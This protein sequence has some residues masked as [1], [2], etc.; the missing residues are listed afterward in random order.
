MAYYNKEE[1]GYILFQKF[2]NE[3]NP[4]RL[5]AVSGKEGYLISWAVDN[6]AKKY[7]GAEFATLDISEIDCLEEEVESIVGISQTVSMFSK[8]RLIIVRN[9]LESKEG[10]KGKSEIERILGS[11]E[12]EAI[13][14]FVFE[15]DAKSGDEKAIYNKEIYKYI[16]EHGRTFKFNTLDRDILKGFIVKRFKDSNREI[17][18]QTVEFLIN[19]SNYLNKDSDYTLYN[20]INDISKIV[21]VGHG[22]VE[23]EEILEVISSSMESN[24]FALLDAI[25]LGNKEEAFRLARDII[26]SGENVFRLIASVASQVELLLMVKEMKEEKASIGEM[27]NVLKKSK[28]PVQKAYGFV[29][30]LSKERL[31]KMLVH[32]YS[33]D[34]NIKSGK[35]EGN[36]A[37]E[38]FIAMA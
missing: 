18:S 37:L 21:D 5:I 36:F 20:L 27:V 6:L 3:E 19:E 8:Q 29:D 13:I 16:E 33:C 31:K 22:A 14:V 10:L 24:S 2:L 35:I 9:Y 23:K 12:K 15:I 30:K 11:V 25:S 1:H 32:I 26:M 28:Y 34:Y 17:S 7:I 38:V 4:R